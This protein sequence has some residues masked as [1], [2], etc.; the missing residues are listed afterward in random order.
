MIDIDNIDENSEFYNTAK[1]AKKQQAE[2]DKDNKQL[3]TVIAVL[4]RICVIYYIIHRS[5]YVVFA[6]VFLA[7]TE[8]PVGVSKLNKRVSFYTKSVA[9]VFFNRS[10]LSF[11]SFASH[12]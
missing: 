2:K 7:S 4:V 3:K 12:V 11:K 8:V 5:H 10:N 9:R 1:Q 6:L